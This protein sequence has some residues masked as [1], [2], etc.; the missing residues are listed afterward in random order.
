MNT[1][2]NVLAAARYFNLEQLLTR[3]VERPRSK[4]KN[5]ET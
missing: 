4:Q 1:R 3:A 2:D 5:I